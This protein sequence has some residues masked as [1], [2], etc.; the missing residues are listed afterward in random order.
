VEFNLPSCMSGAYKYPGVNIEWCPDPFQ[1][2]GKRTG[3]VSEPE[4]W[5]S[6]SE[7]GVRISSASSADPSEQGC[8]VLPPS[9]YTRI[10]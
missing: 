7:N 10:K 9:F 1:L 6:D 5:E 8:S 3:D 4:V 2:S